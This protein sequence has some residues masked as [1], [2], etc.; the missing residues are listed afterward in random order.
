VRGLRRFNGRA[1]KI[2]ATNAVSLRLEVI[3]ARETHFPTSS[4]AAAKARSKQRGVFE[5]EQVGLPRASQVASLAAL[6]H[7][8]MLPKLFR[9]LADYLEET[10]G[11]LDGLDAWVRT[12][13]K[14][15]D[16]LLLPGGEVGNLHDVYEVST[17]GM[18]LRFQPE[19]LLFLE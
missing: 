3:D 10:S 4:A 16:K 5:A 18:S 2:S 12:D 6:Q 9:R 13:P 11:P 17:R 1:P 14:R 19:G 15:D 7:L 8:V